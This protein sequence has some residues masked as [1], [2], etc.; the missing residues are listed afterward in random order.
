MNVF[1]RNEFNGVLAVRVNFAQHSTG[2]VRVERPLIDVR[3]EDRSL[4]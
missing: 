2:L 1:L 3:H 4:G